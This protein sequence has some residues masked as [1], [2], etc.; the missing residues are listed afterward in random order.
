MKDDFLK[1]KTREQVAYEYGINRRTLQ[2]WLKK[3]GILIPR[4]L[5]KPNDL[6]KIYGKY[7]YPMIVRQKSQ[8]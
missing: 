3:D 6:L 8:V 7:G 1:A 5:I 2:R 4:G